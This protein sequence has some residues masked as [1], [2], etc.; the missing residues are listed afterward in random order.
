MKS[1]HIR[2]LVLA[3]LCLALA[4]VLPFLTGQIPQIGSM[5]CPMHIPALLCGFIC[6]WPWGLA[7]GFIAPLL[8]SVMF[9]MPPMFPVAICMAFELA[10]YGAV[11]GMMYRLLPKKPAFVY[12]S[13]IIAMVVGRLVWGSARLVCTIGGATQ[14][15]WAAFLSGALTTAI[16]GIILQIVLIPVIVLALQKAKVMKE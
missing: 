10:A 9:G 16:P 8:R 4:I 3:A 1:N 6:G 14:F 11:S 12:V 15:G 7:V 2:N 13:L 5:L